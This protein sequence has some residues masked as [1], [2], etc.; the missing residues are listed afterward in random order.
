MK[1]IYITEEQKDMIGRI[2][3]DYGLNRIMLNEENRTQKKKCIEIITHNCNP[4]LKQ[5]LD[6]K[7]IDLPSYLRQGLNPEGALYQAVSTNTNGCDK[8]IDYLR[9]N[10]YSQFSIGRHS[11]LTQYIPGIARIACVDC[12]FYV[13]DD[14]CKFCRT[15]DLF[16]CFI[17]LVYYNL[18]YFLYQF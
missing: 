4:L 10:L 9:L 15:S 12:R 13:Y 14:N 17:C 2:M 1:K 7:L 8:F 5:Y 16:Y 18:N 11:L 3:K 6:K